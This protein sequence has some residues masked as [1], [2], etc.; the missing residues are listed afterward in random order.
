MLLGRFPLDVVRNQSVFEFANVKG[1]LVGVRCPPYLQGIYAPGF[2]LH[3]ISDD[4]QKGGHLLE[5]NLADATGHIGYLTQ[6]HLMLPDNE[7]TRTVNLAV[8]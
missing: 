2:H 3:F 4:R 8:K 6:M 1:T 7:K 5:V